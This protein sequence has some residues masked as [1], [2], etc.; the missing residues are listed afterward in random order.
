MRRNMFMDFFVIVRLYFFTVLFFIEGLWIRIRNKKPKENFVTITEPEGVEWLE[1]GEVKMTPKPSQADAMANKVKF[2]LSQVPKEH[3]WKVVLGISLSIFFFLF[4]IIDFIIR[5]TALINAH[6]IVGWV[7]LDLLCGCIL[8]I[9]AR[10]VYKYFKEKRYY[11]ITSVIK[12]IWAEAKNKAE[13]KFTIK[14]I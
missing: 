8:F 3:R 4:G 5:L 7:L 1:E 13:L 11:K 9:I 12:I 14:T 10:G 6:P 2:G